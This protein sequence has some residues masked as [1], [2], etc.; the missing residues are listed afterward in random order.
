VIVFELA[1]DK[2]NTRDVFWLGCTSLTGKD[3][4]EADNIY[5]Q[6]AAREVFFCD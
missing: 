3:Q 6:L 1:M 5:E 4:V 2:G